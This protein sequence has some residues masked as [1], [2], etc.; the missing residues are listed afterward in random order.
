MKRQRVHDGIKLLYVLP[1]KM[2][3]S[4]ELTYVL[5]KLNNIHLL[6]KIVIDEANCIH[7]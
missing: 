3:K 6:S 1:E 5:T 2:L 7:Q 4:E